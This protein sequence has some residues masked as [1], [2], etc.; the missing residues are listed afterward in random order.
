MNIVKKVLAL[1]TC[2]NRKETTV[3]CIKSLNEGNRDI[4]F[5]FIIVDDKS[6]DGTYD[7]LKNID[8]VHVVHGTGSLFYSG[9]MREAIKIAQKYKYNLYDYVLIFNDDVNFFPNSIIKLIEFGNGIEVCVGATCDDKGLLSYGGVVKTSKFRP[10]FKT[11]MSG[12]EKIYCDTFCANCVLI[13][14]KVFENIENI[15]PVYHHAMGDFD[16]G[17]SIKKHGYKIVA[18]DFFVGQCND[19][20]VTGSWRDTS[21]SIKER[22]I[23]K[24]SPKGLPLKEYF[25]YLHKNHNIITAIVYSIIPYMKIILGK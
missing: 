19:N 3:N 13:P 24:E 15:D 16:Y 25:H 8:N 9:G 11:V 2:F 6:N 14:I 4:I 22:I 12:E 21:L 5:D 1:A 18:S 23:K 10:S 17:F 7:E 20:P